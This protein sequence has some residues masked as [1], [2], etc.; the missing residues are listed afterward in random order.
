MSELMLTGVITSLRPL[1]AKIRVDE[2]NGDLSPTTQRLD[3]VPMQRSDSANY[4]H[5]SGVEPF[6]ALRLA[7]RAK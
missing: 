3:G 6:R 5:A 1:F 7:F 4:L 2:C